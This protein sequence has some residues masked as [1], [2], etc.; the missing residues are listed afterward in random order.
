MDYLVNVNHATNVVGYWIFYSNYKKAP[1]LNRK[2]L[3]MICDP[4]VCEEQA[5]N[6]ETL[7]ASVR[8]IHF[9]T[10]LKKDK[11]WY[12]N[13]TTQSY[14]WFLVKTLKGI[15]LICIHIHTQKKL[16]DD[17]QIKNDDS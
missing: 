12:L 5:F 7:F 15:I 13:L 8:Y 16:I 4:Y 10:W 14:T 3:D 11:L 2:P 1:V 17:E 6:F 9:D